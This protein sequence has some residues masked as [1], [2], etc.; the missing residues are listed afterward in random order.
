MSREEEVVV[1]SVFI[2]VGW[3]VNSGFLTDIVDE[4][5]AEDEL[6]IVT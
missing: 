3:L 1:A 6:S 5:T 4:S 2:V